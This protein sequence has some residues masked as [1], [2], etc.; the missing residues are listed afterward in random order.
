MK[1]LLKGIVEFFYRKNPVYDDLIAGATTFSGYAKQGDLDLFRF[2]LTAGILAGVFCVFAGHRMLAKTGYVSSGCRKKYEG[3]FRLPFW[4]SVCSAF[5]FAVFSGFS[6]VVLLR[7]L[8]IRF[9][10]CEQLVRQHSGKIAAAFLL[11]WI[12]YGAGHFFAEKKCFFEKLLLLSQL[13][14][15]LGILPFY[16]FS[17]LYHGQHIRLFESDLLKYTCI[18]TA[19]ALTLWN[20]YSFFKA[21]SRK[22]L[23]SPVSFAITAMLLVFKIP[24]GVIGTDFFHYGEQSI[25]SHQ[26]FQFARLPYTGMVPIHGMCDYFY[27]ILSRIF[28]QGTYSSILAAEVLGNVILAGFTGLVLYYFTENRAVSLGI[29]LCSISWIADLRWVC[30]L[31]FY[32][33]LLSGKRRTDILERFFAWVLLSIAAIAWYPAIGGAAAVSVL[34]LLL[35]EIFVKYRKELFHILKSEERRKWYLKYGGMLAAGLCF[36]PL[37]YQI[38]IYLKEN[39]ATTM[40]VNGTA[41]LDL[42]TDGF[43]KEAFLNLFGFSAALCSILLFVLDQEKE[44]RERAGQ[45]LL[46]F[47]IFLLVIANYTFVRVDGNGVRGKFCSL[48]LLAMTAVLLL[49]GYLKKR[50]AS[51]F[52]LTGL[53]GLMVLAGGADIL[54]LPGNIF[55]EKKTEESLILV[56]CEDESIGLS[57]LGSC[58]SSEAVLNELKVVSFCA[59]MAAPKEEVFLDLTNKVSYYPILDRESPISYS[60]IYN[61]SNR[62]MEKNVIAELT[63]QMPKMILLSPCIQTDAIPV[64][65]RSFRVFQWILEQGY[66]PF[67]YYN[68]LFLIRGEA[69]WAQPAEEEFSELMHLQYLGALPGLWGGEKIKEELT[70]KVEVGYTVLYE[71]GN[72][73]EILLDRPVDGQEVD[74]IRVLLADSD[75]DAVLKMLYS[76]K[77]EAYTEQKGH[78]MQIG[79]RELL[80]P[81]SAS[82]YWD[83]SKEIQKLRFF[84]EDTKELLHG[85][86]LEFEVLKKTGETEKTGGRE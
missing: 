12:A 83:Y 8:A 67:Q 38:L 27:G 57:A 82:P 62:L 79:K 56:D 74:F 41:M 30:I 1:E 52:L 16:R 22:N 68:A 14:L 37:F 11:L 78:V 69:G 5:Y 80:I 49:G 23:V 20:L 2:F 29:L 7:L 10:Q 73:M 59:D 70:E 15:P 61:V 3:F 36:L 34:P 39:A 18:L 46:V 65:Y 84:T 9:S 85:A 31:P 33:V 24:D 26:L 72:D 32:A 55:L 44:I 45:V 21:G 53:A 60:S 25:M 48:L 42:F 58:F 35:Y 17:Y 43:S 4:N 51:F 50:P 63:E 6:G 40:A 86:R 47:G 19:A 81:V 75:R 77:E 66:R 54:K 28:F 76:A 64:S 71:D 13:F